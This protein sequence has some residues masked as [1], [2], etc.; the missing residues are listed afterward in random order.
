MSESTL[1]TPALGNRTSD[2]ARKLIVE[3]DGV[4]KRYPNCDDPAV[5][6][7]DLG[8]REGEFFS[9]LGSSGSGKTT[10]L[11]MIAGFEKPSEGTLRLGGEDVTDVPPYRREVNTVFQNYALF[12][13]YSV[14]KNVAYPLRM[15]KVPKAEIK[16]RVTEAL[17]KVSMDGFASRLPHQLSGGQRQRVALARALVGN[18]K[19]LLL[20][21]PL[22]AL[23]LKL[24]ESMLVVL[25]HLQREVGITFVYVTHDQGEALAMSD[26]VAVMNNGRIE[27]VGSPEE[28]YSRPRTAFVAGF[29]GKTNLLACT[30]LDDKSA[31]CG[32]L[33]I[34]LGEPAPAG[35]FQVS[36]RP[37]DIEIGAGAGALTN[38]FPAVVEEVIYF[39]HEQEVVLNASGQRLVARVRGGAPAAPGDRVPVGWD[40]ASGVAVESGPA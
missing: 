21:E 37:E 11:R 16:Q 22:G 31:R 9:I 12:P 10:T 4:T 24:R 28:I 19:L 36:V 17:A 33:E 26:R 40:A 32:S 5:A 15:R 8:I 7:M 29:I 34:A 38:R 13:H 3:L 18:P 35:A 27:Q 2:P 39:G 25:K 6:S 30:R 23:D 14:E 20:D 1:S